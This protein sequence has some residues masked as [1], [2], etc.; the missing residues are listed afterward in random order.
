[1]RLFLKDKECEN[2]SSSAKTTAGKIPEVRASQ[3]S[4]PCEDVCA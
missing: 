2:L 4:C 1:M 3:V